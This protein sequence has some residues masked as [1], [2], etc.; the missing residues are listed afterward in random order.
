MESESKKAEKVFLI[1]NGCHESYVDAALLESYFLRTPFFMQVNQIEDADLILFL[2]CS[3]MQ[4][5]E[6]E[7]IEI[8]KVLN[9]KKKPG[10]KVLVAGCI[11]KVRPES[12]KDNPQQ[13]SDLLK[14]ISGL[15]RMNKEAQEIAAHFPYRPYRGKQG[16]I[17]DAVRAKTRS[18]RVAEYTSPQKQIRW[19]SEIFATIVNS[20]LSKYKEFIES[21]VDVWTEKTYAVKI[22][23]GCSGNCTYCSIKQ[24]RGEICSKPLNAVLNEIRIGIKEGYTDF[25]LIG[26]DIGDYGKDIGTDL[27]TL[28]HSIVT[29]PEHLQLRLRNLNPRWL[30]PNCN[31]LGEIMKSGKISYIQSPIQ[32]CSNNILKKMN[33]GYKAEDYLRAIKK[34]RNDYPNVFLKTQIITGFPGESEEDFL[35]SLEL[36]KSGLFNYVDVFPFTPRPNTIASTLPDQ[37]DYKLVIKR[38]RKLIMKSL[39]ILGPK[40]LLKRQRVHSNNSTSRR[41]ASAHFSNPTSSDIEKPN[42]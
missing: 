36:F 41:T 21:R 16:D 22:S 25:A 17:I 7:T 35:P 42:S 40:A 30:I 34:I 38:R 28:L 6:E 23:T 11:S 19:S 8:T 2:G 12:A 1:S 14:D 24:S 37:L 10:A 29:L 31:I 3:V 26:T 5:K 32:S 9:K 20:L 13:Y 27:Q 33:R 18:L 15:F 39:F 4:T